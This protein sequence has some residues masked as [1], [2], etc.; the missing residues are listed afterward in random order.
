MVYFFKFFKGSQLYQIVALLLL[1][2]VLVIG[3]VPGYLKGHW[4]WQQPPAVVSLKK[5]KQIHHTGLT[6]PGWQTTEQREEP[7]GGYKWS[8]QEIE[9]NNSPIKA[10]LLLL[11]QNGPKDQPQVEWTEIN[12]WAQWDK[13]QFRSAEFTVQPTQA[14][15]NSEVK[16]QASF[17]RATTKQKTF[18]V[19]QW[20]AWQNGGSTSP[21]P[22]FVADQVAKWHKKRAPWVAVT[23]LIP[24]E[25][26]GQVEKTWQDTESLG[27]TVQSALMSTF[28]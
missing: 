6:L 18:A 16:V 12:S 11:P 2:L 9:K 1:L 13:S 23:I 7:I 8:Y 3:A 10:I 22:W 14:S 5:L 4:Q 26:F 24:M 28:L 20:Y 15:S 21:L 25:P 19:L 27:K 17:F